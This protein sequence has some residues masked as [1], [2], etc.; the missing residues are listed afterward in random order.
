MLSAK[1]KKYQMPLKTYTRAGMRMALIQFWW[2]F[3]V[4]VALIILG[5]IIGGGWV[6]GL[7]I[8]AVVLTLLYL[9]FWYIQFYAVS[10]VPEGKVLFERL[11]YELNNDQFLIKKNQKEGMILKWDQIKKVEK[12]KDAFVFKLSVA[13][14]F[15]LPFDI[16]NSENDIKFTEALLKRK[17][18]LP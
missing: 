13:Q 18:L 14:F 10:Q 16:F 1:T 3:L 15:Y 7:S 12:W 8:T 9:L 6:L 5:F 4:P 17:K 2:A 11:S